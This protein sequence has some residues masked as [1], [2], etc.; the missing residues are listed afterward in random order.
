MVTLIRGD[1]W[2]RYWEFKNKDTNTAIDLTGVVAIVTV[3]DVDA[4]VLAIATGGNSRITVN[5]IL[6]KVTMIMP[7]SVTRTFEITTHKFDLELTYPDGTVQTAERDKLK[8]VEDV[9]YA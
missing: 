4:N 8:I 5:G 1:T 6:G 3:R 2:K 9:T 7:A